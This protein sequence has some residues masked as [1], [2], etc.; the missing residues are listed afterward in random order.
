MQQLE[1]PLVQPG[2]QPFNMQKYCKAYG[3]CGGQEQDEGHFLKMLDKLRSWRER[4]YT[5][6]VPQ[7]VHD[8]HT[9]DYTMARLNCDPALKLQAYLHC[10]DLVIF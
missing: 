5:A 4:Y 6:I 10:K 7:K 2:Q 8:N 3:Q 9:S 1:L